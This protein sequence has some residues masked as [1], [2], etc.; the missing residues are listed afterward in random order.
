MKPSVRFAYGG[1]TPDLSMTKRVIPMMVAP[2]P[3]ASATVY[4]PTS[5]SKPKATKMPMDRFAMMRQ[6]NVESAMASSADNAVSAG[7]NHRERL[8][9]ESRRRAEA[10]CMEKEDYTFTQEGVDRLKR[11]EARLTMQEEDKH[12]RKLMKDEAARVYQE[13]EKE[14]RRVEAEERQVLLDKHKI[15]MEALK[16]KQDAEND[17][18]QQDREARMRKMKEASDRKA[19]EEYL[20]NEAVKKAVLEKERQAQQEQ[21]ERLHMEIE[22]DA[23]RGRMQ[24]AAEDALV[25]AKVAAE[26]AKWKAWEE[27]EAAREASEQAA[28]RAQMAAQYEEDKKR[29]MEL[30]RLRKET[31]NRLKRIEAMDHPTSL[32]PPSSPPKGYEPPAKSMYTHIGV[33]KIGSFCLNPSV[34]KPSVGEFKDVAL[35]T[36]EQLR[37]EHNTCVVCDAFQ[38]KLNRPPTLEEKTEIQPLYK[39][40]SDVE[41]HLRLVK[42]RLE[43]L[44]AD[45]KAKKAQNSSAFHQLSAAASTSP[46]AT[47]IHKADTPGVLLTSTPSQQQLNAMMDTSNATPSSPPE[48]DILSNRKKHIKQEIQDWCTHFQQQHGHPP[49]VAD[50][51]DVQGMYEE[52]ATL[53]AK[54]K[55]LKYSSAETI[56]VAAVPLA[57]NLSLDTLV[58]LVHDALDSPTPLPPRELAQRILAI[59]EAMDGQKCSAFLKVD[60]VEN[61]SPAAHAGLQVGD[62]VG[63]FGSVVKAPTATHST[64]IR[65]VVRTCADDI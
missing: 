23:E 58:G 27:A 51:K 59:H 47:T 63:R 13:L 60:G 36:K 31:E 65:Q 14:R 29:R 15:E 21:M 19:R 62:V 32:P 4:P 57:A 1:G 6:V 17:R 30:H 56:L 26:E 52:Y 53:D 38:A 20:A 54:I 48:L 33:P 2:P 40:Y 8:Q 42:H 43:G 10:A 34:D 18:K 37:D 5:S 24:K 35:L 50:K 25:Q 46:S 41:A 49:T 9:Q 7:Q 61:E 22:D 16:A 45:D 64:L 44:V 3:S 11:Q 55:T 12:M 39:R 28:R